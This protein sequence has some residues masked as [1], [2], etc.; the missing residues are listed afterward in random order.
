MS[1]YWIFVIIALCGTA[2]NGAG[3]SIQKY[4][5]V[6]KDR[7]NN[8]NH[9]KEKQ[10]NILKSTIGSALNSIFKYFQKNNKKCYFEKSENLDLINHNENNLCDDEGHFNGQ[11]DSYKTF[12]Q[13]KY[14]YGLNVLWIL[15]ITFCYTG[16]FMA[17]TIPLSKLSIQTIAPL[18]SMCVISSL[19]CTSILKNQKITNR[20]IAGIAFTVA[21]GI[22]IV[23]FTAIN[24][25]HSS[26]KFLSSEKLIQAFMKIPVL[27]SSIVLYQLALILGFMN[28]AQ[29]TGTIKWF[30]KKSSLKVIFY[31]SVASLL[32]VINLS[33]SKIASVYVRARLLDPISNADNPFEAIFKKYFGSTSIIGFDKSN[34]SDMME[35]NSLSGADVNSKL[36]IL[37]YYL[38]ESVSIFGF[39][40]STYT[41]IILSVVF[42]NSLVIEG[43]R[44]RGLSKYRPSVF[45]AFYFTTY[46]IVATVVDTFV[47]GELLPVR[48]ASQILLQTIGTGLIIFGF[49]LLCTDR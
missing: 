34:I 39:E 31:S 42:I 48:E 23:F 19:L 5:F 40:I 3:Q 33:I 49:F 2:L 6:Q 17:I 9:I 1:E 44:Q 4:S 35:S 22:F 45:R 11:E 16:E 24:Q 13:K 14:F 29:L 37:P 18:S 12:S 21:G 7:L 27:E 25:S 26:I 15:G 43:N 8:N 28:I 32:A 36:N 20:E 46:M 41:L 10:K 47:F 38:P 30:T